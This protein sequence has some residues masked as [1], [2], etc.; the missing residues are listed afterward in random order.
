MS[1][2]RDILCKLSGKGWIY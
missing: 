1:V 2:E